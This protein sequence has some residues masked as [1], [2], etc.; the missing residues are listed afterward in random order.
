MTAR[1]T[2][3]ASSKALLLGALLAILAVS[4]KE[5]AKPTSGGTE[6]PVIGVSAEVHP[7]G[8]TGQARDYSLRVLN[9][10]DCNVEPHFRPPKGVVKV[11]VE[12]EIAGL[13]PKEVPV[14]PF[15]AR[16]VSADG[17][18]YEASLAGCQPVLEASRVTEGQT[19]AGWL[20]FDVPADASRLRLAY[21]PV[22]I[23]VGKEELLFDV[24]R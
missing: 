17:A 24:G 7:L 2:N 15:Y 6:V 14:N 19:K 10:R 9:V 5:E 1:E 22:V 13:S 16:L 12:V 23:G 3:Y 20:T 18:R 4:C 11:G 8:A 21:E